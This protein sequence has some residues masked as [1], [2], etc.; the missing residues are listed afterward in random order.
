MPPNYTLLKG[1]GQAI[2]S[3]KLWM[4]PCELQVSHPQ[5]LHVEEA[6][7]SSST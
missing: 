1:A 2:K 4:K 6:P 3:Q 7:N 5:N